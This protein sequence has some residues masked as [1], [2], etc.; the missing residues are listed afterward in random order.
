MVQEAD[1]LVVAMVAV[2]GNMRAAEVKVLV[3]LYADMVAVA[4]I[5]AAAVELAN[6]WIAS[7]DK[8]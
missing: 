6:N 4:R 5:Q 8:Q 3:M 7:T 2:M 1:L